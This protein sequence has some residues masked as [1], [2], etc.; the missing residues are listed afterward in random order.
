MTVRIE[1]LTQEDP[2]YILPFFEEFLRQ[3]ADA[4][5]IE[6]ISCCR[7][8]GNRPRRKLLRELAQLYGPLGLARLLSRAATGRILGAVPLSPG[9][10]RYFSLSQLCQAHNIAYRSI[11]SPNAPEFV[12]DVKARGCDLIVSVACP[13][14]LKK[15]LLDLPPLGCIN[16]HHAPLPRYKGMMPTFWQMY[17]GERSVGLTIHS[18]SE[19]IDEGQALLREALNIEPDETLDH[20]IRRSKRHAAHCLG[21]VLRSI[22]SDTLVT[23]PLNQEA[24]SYFT[25]PT[26]AEIREFQ[27]RGLRAI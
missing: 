7:T 8:M 14:I 1:F 3:N 24:G 18:M 16:I 5:T 4:W 22:A 23:E 9:K 6:G 27:R 20:L 2:I 15:T 12:R 11:G 13:F 17:H 21:R 19:K 25:F 26:F 10:K